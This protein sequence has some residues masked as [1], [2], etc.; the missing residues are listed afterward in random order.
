[1]V[2]TIRRL[3]NP[4]SDIFTVLYFYKF[5]KGVVPGRGNSSFLLVNQL[6]ICK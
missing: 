3:L 2:Q 6:L 5:E 1:M 4:E